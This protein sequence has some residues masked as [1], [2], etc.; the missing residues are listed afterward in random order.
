M[1]KVTWKMAVNVE[2]VVSRL[3]VSAAW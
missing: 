2:V 3:L 1:R